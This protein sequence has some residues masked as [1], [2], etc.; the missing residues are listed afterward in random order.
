MASFAY[1][2]AAAVTRTLSGTMKFATRNVRWTVIISILLIF[3]SFVSAAIIQMRL[4]R[5]HAL[6]QARAIESRR[7]AEMASD[8]AEIFNRYASLGN[9]FANA[10]LNTETSAALSEAGGAALTNIAVLD[11]SGHLLSE[12]KRPP[13]ELLPLDAETVSRITAG[14]AVLAIGPS[15]VL[16]LS[17]SGHIVLVQLNRS[18]LLPSAGMEDAVL[19][20]EDGRL[21]AIGRNW[22][23]LP[24]FAA[25]SLGGRK[26]QA[27]ILDLPLGRRLVA[28]A[29][30]AG[31]PVTAGAS[32]EVGEALSDWY[33]ALPIYFFFILGP[34]F[35]G[36]GLAVVFV[37]EFERRARAV[38]AV[39]TIKSKKSD[40][41]KLLIQLAEAERHAVEADRSKAEFLMHMSHELRTPLNAIIGFSEV[42]AQGL[43]G[44]AGHPKY[45]EYARDIGKAGRTLHEKIGDILEFASL[46]AGNQ[47]IRLATIDAGAIAREAV[48]EIEGRAFSRKIRVTAE[49]SDPVRCIADAHC[50]KRALNN[51]LNNALRY[52]PEGGSLHVQIRSDDTSVHLSVRDTG[53]GFSSSEA[54]RAGTPFARFERTGAATGA[55]LGLAIASGLVRR[56]GGA[57]RISGRPGDGTVAELK[58]RRA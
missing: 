43:F 46:E 15:I 29:P 35:V 56:M 36:G 27:R 48:E 42:I 10:Q 4:D 45:E 39:R 13:D 18:R 8:L 19:A 44:K 53:L 22:R 55:G 31:W 30:V 23:D 2:P 37:R 20:D 32:I 6:D 3:G 58:L 26:P 14:R 17:N 5:M 16:A 12:M 52:T 47:P 34:A 51:L 11:E 24:S 40:E 9:A 50:L 1:S 41:A 21:L 49:L 7:A 38:E 28:L 33:G 54:A 25:L 57:L